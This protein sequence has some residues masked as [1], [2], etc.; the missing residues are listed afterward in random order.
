MGVVENISIGR[1]PVQGPWLQRRVRVCFN[2]DHTQY[3]MGV[4]VRDDRE[5]PGVS[6]IRLDSGQ[7]I[8]TT[9]CQFSLV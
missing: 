6:I 7:Y 2:Y 8:L 5:S 4:I 1:F 3:T 9:E